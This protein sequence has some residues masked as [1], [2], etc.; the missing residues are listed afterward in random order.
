MA[1]Y[2]KPK[3]KPPY[4]RNVFYPRHQLSRRET[5]AE[6]EKTQYIIFSLQ[7]EKKG[8]GNK[9]N[10]LI[11]KNNCVVYIIIWE[12][13]VYV[14]TGSNNYTFLLYHTFSLLF[15]ALNPL[16]S[17]P[18][19]PLLPFSPPHMRIGYDIQSLNAGYYWWWLNIASIGW[20][21]VIFVIQW[22][23]KEDTRHT[24]SI[25]WYTHVRHDIYLQQNLSGEGGGGGGG[26]GGGVGVGGYQQLETHQLPQF[27]GNIKLLLNYWMSRHLWQVAAVF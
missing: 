12:V 13:W 4:R 25:V 24:K 14:E 23:T 3:C 22:K 17:S 8:H 20:W 5:V 19:I 27:F 2:D 26:E 15:S 7:C 11:E 21:L 6:P 9:C 16:L 10:L 1:L 18:S